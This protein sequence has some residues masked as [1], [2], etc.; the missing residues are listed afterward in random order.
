MLKVY[1]IRYTAQYQRYISSCVHCATYCPRI[2][3]RFRCIG[4]I[5]LNS[6]FQTFKKL[7]I[8]GTSKQFY[9]ELLCLDVVSLRDKTLL[10]KL[11]YKDAESAS[12]VLR[13]KGTQ[14]LHLVIIGSGK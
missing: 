9:L 14:S 8:K 1:T 7:D 3:L 6:V 10:D 13:F 2:L 4:T 12:L 5:L 11:F